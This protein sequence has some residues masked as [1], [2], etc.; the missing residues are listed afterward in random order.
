MSSGIRCAI[1]AIAAALAGCDEAGKGG[2]L[3]AAG[4]AGALAAAGTAGTAGAL[5]PDTPEGESVELTQTGARLTNPELGI[6]GSVFVYADPHTAL[7][8][9]SNLTP[10]LDPSL[11]DACIEGIAAMVDQGSE[12]CATMQFTPPATDCFGEYSGAGV[13]MSLNQASDPSASFTTPALPFDASALQG[14]VFDIDGPIV[15]ARA[16][17]A[18]HVETS[19]DFNAASDAGVFCNLP[20]VKLVAGTNY[21]LFSELVDRCFRLS[22]DPANP[23]AETVQSKLTRITWRVRTNDRS[24]VPFDFCVSNVRALLK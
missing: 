3:A 12:I 11:G 6:Q 7:G 15:P 23:S 14:F 18:F 20:S 22:D 19:T 4:A 9:T 13:A 10:L 16:S 8:M 21:V 5:R 2:A 17:L 24:P 1:F